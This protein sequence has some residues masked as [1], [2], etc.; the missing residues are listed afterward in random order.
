MVTTN[1]RVTKSTHV[2]IR[3]L[4]KALGLDTSEVLDLLMNR[5]PPDIEEEFQRRQEWL[6]GHP[7]GNANGDNE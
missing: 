7:T 1:I 6:K 5:L 4:A 2:R 3:E